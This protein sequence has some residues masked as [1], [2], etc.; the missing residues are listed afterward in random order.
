MP[1]LRYFT[2]GESHGQGLVGILEGLPANVAISIEKIN[3]QLARRQQGYGRGGRMKI[4][5]DQVQILSGIRHD[6]S[7]GSPISFLIQNRDWKNWDKIMA[8]SGTNP[9]KKIVEVPRPG[10]ADLSGAIKYDQSD[11]RNILERAS[12]R[13]TA[14]R[15][16]LGAIARQFLDALGIGIASHVIQIAEVKSEKTLID[17]GSVDFNFD[18]KNLNEIADA[19][20]VRCVD[21]TTAEKMME[22]IDSAKSNRDTCGGIF[23]VVAFNL[24]VGLGS[25]VH[26]DRRLDSQ[27]AAAMMG[28]QAMKGVEIGDG[29]GGA[30][31]FGSQVHDEI[32]YDRSENKFYRKQ[33]NA[34]GLEGGMTNGMPVVVR[35][36]MK[37]IATLM[38]PLDS[39]ELESKKSVTAHVERSDV[40]AVPAAAVIGEAMLALTIAGSV[41]DKFGGDSFGEV[42]KRYDGWLEYT[43]NR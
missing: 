29:F 37:P 8:V 26:W 10:H 3:Q 30:C 6:K 36:A 5:T 35:V 17:F 12:A 24:P 40:T 14:T 11:M 15:V 27:I 33:N 9:Q 1:H 41:L 31:R 18:L 19:S 43:S 38:Q 23:E 34:G 32:Y 20:P 22:T 42:K 16:A 13:E 7:L 28:I 39:I 21:K 2:A 4:E 25:H